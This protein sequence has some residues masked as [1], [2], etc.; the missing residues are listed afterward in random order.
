MKYCIALIL[1]SASAMAKTMS[2]P[3]KAAEP[4]DS[5]ASIGWETVSSSVVEPAYSS[6]LCFLNGPIPASFCLF[7]SFTHYTIEI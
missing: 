7:S 5:F 6:N 3:Y 1:M 2:M 4:R